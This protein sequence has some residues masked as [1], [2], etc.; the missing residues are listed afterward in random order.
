MGVIFHQHENIGLKVDQ[1]RNQHNCIAQLS[2]SVLVMYIHGKP[3]R[4][5]NPKK[6]AV[7]VKRYVI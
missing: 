4:F 7:W 5:F 1:T 3:V 2:T 6:S